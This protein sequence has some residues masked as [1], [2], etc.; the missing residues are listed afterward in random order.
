MKS[1]FAAILSVVLLGVTAQAQPYPTQP[2]RL[3]VP[4]AAGGLPDTVARIVAQGL[5]ERLGQSVIVE[6]R[7]GGNGSVAAST[8]AA[9]PADGYT[10]L[11]TDGSMLSINPL[12]F[13]TVTYDARRDF[14]PVAL[15]GRAPL[16]LASHPDL[17]VNSFKEFVE[18]VRANPGQVNYGSSGVGSTHHLSM[19]A[20]KSALKLNIAHIPYRGTGQS[21][22]ALLGGH[23]QVL[24]SAY[25]SLAG[26]VE[27]NKLKLLATNGSQ[28]SAQAPG[29]P[30]IADV[31]PGFDFAV[32]VGMLARAGT[33]PAIV[34]KI[35]VQSVAAV[36]SPEALKQYAAAG[37]EQATAMPAEFQKEILNEI[38]RV[39]AAVKAAG[40]KAQ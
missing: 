34:E 39:S 35:A 4:Y 7:P 32:M 9:A 33:P 28:R 31:V 13:K 27:S 2:I 26:A 23:V 12:L 20:L 25:P 36:K 24:F 11:V 21:V 40:I 22:P 1:V 37:I 6:N 17:P 15:L 10:F 3:L 8:L 30:P 38:D 19:E 16:F 14:V 5:T 29:V 18:Y